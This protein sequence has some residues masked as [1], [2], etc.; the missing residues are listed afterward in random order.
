MSE[1]HG[2][3]GDFVPYIAHDEFRNGAAHG[4]LRIVVDPKLARPY[5]VRRTRIDGLAM[6]CIAAGAALALAGQAVAGIVLV[7]LGV[8]ANRLVRHQA[9]K[10]V[11][12]LALEHADVYAE[13][14]SNGVM[15][16]RRA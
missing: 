8:I 15:E 14:T 11:L 2:A 3:D 12:Q 4:R 13:V 6:L 7:A 9:G 1:A 16:V 5:V 10:I